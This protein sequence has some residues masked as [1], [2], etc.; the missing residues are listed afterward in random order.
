MPR[1]IQA[2]KSSGNVFAD[3][4]VAQPDVALAKAKLAHRIS[5]IIQARKLKQVEVGQILG[6]GQGRVSAL[7]RG[8]LAGFSTER[9]FR[10]LNA[11]DQNI[12]IVVRKKRTSD[13]RA[14]VTVAGK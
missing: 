7:V 12:E 1:L 13:D 2:E 3:L 11:F 10:F 14:R 9:M 5:K 8:Q 4:D 6:I